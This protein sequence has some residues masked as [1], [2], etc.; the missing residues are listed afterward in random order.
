MWFKNLLIYRLPAPWNVAAADIAERLGRR[1][2]QA[3]GGLDAQSLGWVAPREGGELVHALGRQYLAALG[4]E[5]KLLPASV[6][7]QFARDRARQIEEEEGR[8]VGRKELRDIRQRVTDELL[9]RAFVR[10]RTTRVWI[11]AENGWLAIDA[12]APA[13]GEELLGELRRALH[14]LPA[15]LLDTVRSPAAAMTDWMARGEAPAGF[16]IDQDLELRSPDEGRVRYLRHTL[17]GEEIRQHIA[18]GKAA[19]RLGMTWNERISFVLTD[20]LQL[21][22]LAFLDVVKEA[23]QRGAADEAER[24]DLDFALMAGELSRLLADLTG[25]LGGEAAAG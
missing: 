5:Q 25:T 18:A 4:V 13:K 6:V 8:R 7:N 9:P 15:R 16:S 14:E 20:K 2:L 21:K 10:R 17:E 19:V 22:R 24:F 3:C 1:P 11:D 12:A 23:S